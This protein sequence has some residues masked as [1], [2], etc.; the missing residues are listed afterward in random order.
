MVD[1]TGLEKLRPCGRLETY[2][3][4]RHYLGFYKSVG[5]TAA[6]ISSATVSTSLEKQIFQALR[7]VIS[8][9]SNLSAITVNEEKSFPDVYFARL[10]EIDLRTCVEF[11]ERVR[12]F[13]KNGEADEELD[14]LLAKQ[15]SR[16]FKDEYGNNPFW[17]LVVVTSPDRPKEISV[18]W[19]FHHA[20]ADGTSAFLLHESFVD[21]LNS[22]APEADA[23]PIVI[24]PKS[25]L[26]P[27]LEE[28]HPLPISWPFLLHAI[29]GL[30]LPS[31]FNKRPAKLWTGN[32]VPVE[33]TT[34]PKLNYRTHVVSTESTKKLAQIS[35]K[36][37]TSVTATLQCLIAASL[38]ASLPTA[39][40]EKI[41]IEC[42]ISM[43]R[44][45]NGVAED[46]MTNAIT[47]YGYL[48]E[49]H[50]TTPSNDTAEVDV[51]RYFSWDEARAVKS[52]IQAEVANE[53]RD[54]PIA[55]LKY[56]SDLPQFFKDKLGK[57]RNPSTEFSNIGVYKNK[58]LGNE[59]S[60]KIGR[61]TFSQSPNLTSCPF[62]VNA[63]T[64]GDGN[65]VLNFCWNQGAVDE[66]VIAR[67]IE[68]VAKGLEHLVANHETV[69]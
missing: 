64:G 19:F 32:H 46:Q 35:R 50:T 47:Q 37:K 57:P 56:V 63:V 66:A 20:L 24:S 38:F 34:A 36:E 31:V 28:L 16:D 7:K 21:A 62:C 1:I 58:E 55:L 3:T 18:S 39:E 14:A 41:K 4:A 67:V 30:I 43:R 10:P 22:V 45:L 54:N 12:P 5:L 59:G 6:Y 26:V 48:H 2:S 42:P 15:H 52:V 60:W 33:V 53:G 8:K 25:A 49:R 27:S 11:H 69:P 13:P 9:H 68:G 51:L 44:F 23:D 29:L 17:R 65:A 61:M 40:W